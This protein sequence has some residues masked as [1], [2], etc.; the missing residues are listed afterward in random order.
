MDVNHLHQFTDP[1]VT[2]IKF[3]REVKLFFTNSESYLRRGI[4]WRRVDYPTVSLVFA[5]SHLRPSPIVFGVDINFTNYD[6]EPPSVKFIDPFTGIRL[7][8]G[9]QLPPIY[10]VIP[11]TQPVQALHLVQ[12]MPG[13]DAFLCIPGIREYH[14][15]PAHSGDSWLLYRSRGEGSL[16]FIIDHLHKHSMSGIGGYNCQITIS[17]NGL[18]F[19]PD[20]LPR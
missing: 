5:A 19:Q 2:R 12:A 11:N 17:V 15:H 16:S 20:R 6:F 9:D 3:D 1:E 18:N 4:F 14:Q 13:E 8:G 10:Q 7:R